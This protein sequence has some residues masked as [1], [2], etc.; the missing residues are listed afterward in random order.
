M[1]VRNATEADIE[2]CNDVWAST[3]SGLGPGPVPNQP[4][5]MHEL[6]TGRLVVAEVDG[7][8]VGFG[9]TVVRSGVLY[10]VDLFVRP[11]HQSQ[12]I[13]RQLLDT[14]CVDHIGPLFTFASADPRAQQ[15][16]EQHGM[17][18]VEQY[19]YLDAVTETLAPWATDVSVVAASRADILALDAAASG[20]ARAIDI[21]YAATIG[22]MWYLARRNDS[23]VGAFAIAA[24]TWWNP[25][26]PRGARLGPVMAADHADVAPIL[27][28]ALVACRSLVPRPDV[29]S[30]FAPSSL[31]ALPSL[32]SAGFEVI[33]TDLFMA[34]DP[35]LIDR[36]RY[37]PTVDTP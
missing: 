32:L 31:P 16:Y 28:A 24:P 3:Q 25:W 2:R 29:V 36:R 34:S 6:N 9:G 8:V 21:D 26:H 13:G 1:I 33:D 7:A 15:L 18:A 20:R 37:L 4:L 30:T 12:G 10:L 11:A 23:C 5:S 27:A 17:H 22:S 35:G 14:L 19:H